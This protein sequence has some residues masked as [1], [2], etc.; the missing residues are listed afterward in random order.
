[1][2]TAPG[3]H[4]TSWLPPS[5]QHWVNSLD[6]A[7]KKRGRL[8]SPITPP[9]I[10]PELQESLKQSV[11]AQTSKPSRDNMPELMDLIQTLLTGTNGGRLGARRNV[12]M[13]LKV[14]C[15]AV[16][17]FSRKGCPLLNHGGCEGAERG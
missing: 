15:K 1:M 16:W 7:L 5:V 2:T 13:N 4:H 10:A 6:S 12:K 8:W 14:W 17:G 3:T 9:A 11:W